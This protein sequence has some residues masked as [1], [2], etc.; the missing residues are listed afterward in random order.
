MAE[1]YCILVLQIAHQGVQNL[2]FP[3]CPKIYL[4]CSSFHLL[5][6]HIFLF[7]SFFITI[8]YVRASNVSMNIA[9]PPN[10]SRAQFDEKVARC[11][12]ISDQSIPSIALSHYSR[13]STD[14]YIIISCCH[15]NIYFKLLLS[16]TILFCLLFYFIVFKTWRRKIYVRGQKFKVTQSERHDKWF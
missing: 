1:S 10:S 2:A 15:H 12:L 5:L 6:S 9:S 7:L 11:A 13:T 4:P 14:F 3:L 16:M 8:L